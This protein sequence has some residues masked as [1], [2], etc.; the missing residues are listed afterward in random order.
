MR[1]K[2]SNTCRRSCPSRAVSRRGAGGGRTCGLPHS[3]RALCGVALMV[4]G[5]PHLLPTRF[6]GRQ[7]DWSQQPL[8]G[9]D[10]LQRCK[11]QP[12][13]AR[14]QYPTRYLIRPKPT[15]PVAKGEESLV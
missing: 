15:A 3:A 5:E 7:L 8:G 9:L 11:L 2:A 12:V 14:T 1:A 4:E 10:R 13:W 6:L